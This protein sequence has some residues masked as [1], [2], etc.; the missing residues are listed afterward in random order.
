LSFPTRRSSDLVPA[1]LIIPVQSVTRGLFQGHNRMREPAILQI[2]EQ[3]LRV[4]FILG[5]AYIVR[6]VL[7]GKVVTAVAYS[8]FAA[9][10]GAVLSMIYLTFRLKQLHTALSREVEE[11]KNEIYIS[12]PNLLKDIIITSIP[13]VIM[14]TGLTVFN[15]IDQQTFAPLMRF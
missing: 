15:F 6:Q 2:I 4:I 5:S 8:T 10:V 12:T 13:F 7:A 3:L 1:L 11:S 9:F 14:S